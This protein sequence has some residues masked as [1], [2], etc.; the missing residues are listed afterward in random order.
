MS[1][2]AAS[3]I[4]YASG[5]SQDCLDSGR[6]LALEYNMLPIREIRRARSPLR[7]MAGF[8]SSKRRQRNSVRHHVPPRAP[9]KVDSDL[10][11][12]RAVS[13]QTEL[14]PSLAESHITQGHA[15]L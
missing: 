3:V 14:T 7:F 11:M 4:F 13:K 6:K 5:Y 2:W 1:N 9:L 12:R 10:A 8:P 15:P